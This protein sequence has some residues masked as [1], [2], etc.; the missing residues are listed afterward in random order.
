MNF[1]IVVTEREGAT[2]HEKDSGTTTRITFTK[3]SFHALNLI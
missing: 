1:L 2:K 3:K